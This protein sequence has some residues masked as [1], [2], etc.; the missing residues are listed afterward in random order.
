MNEKQ[1]EKQNVRLDKHVNIEI[2]YHAHHFPYFHP[3]P[4]KCTLKFLFF[5]KIKK[6]QKK[7]IKVFFSSLL[8]SSN[9]II[10]GQLSV[11]R[12]EFFFLIVN[13]IRSHFVSTERYYRHYSNQNWR[14]KISL[15]LNRP[16]GI[17]FSTVNMWS[18]MKKKVFDPVLFSRISKTCEKSIRFNT[19]Q[20]FFFIRGP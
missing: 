19:Y 7:I 11:N 16:C 5:I 3:N 14:L 4:H 2:N 20:Y 15:R 9:I 1:K 13:R 6:K 10:L 8:S 12:F 18:R 17:W